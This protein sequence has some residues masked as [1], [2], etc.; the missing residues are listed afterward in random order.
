[1][2]PALV[3]SQVAV[4]VVILLLAF[5]LLGA[6]RGQEVLRWRLDQL[7]ALAP[8]RAGRTG[9]RP[10]TSAPNFT[11]PDLAGRDVSLCDF[12]G[13]DVLLVFTQSGCGPCQAVMPELNRLHARGEVQVVVVNNGDADAARISAA[14]VR[15]RFPVLVQD[16]FALSKKYEVFA[17][18]FAFLID[19]A[20]VVRSKGIAG[21]RQYIGYVVD[22]A[23]RRADGGGRAEPEPVGAAAEA[24]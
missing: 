4:W 1:M 13:R 23:R 15:A 7:Q 2:G 21:T 6:L 19:G 8:V 16:K 12:A 3:V 18:P 9:L 20:G 14:E 5:L 11:L 22:G 17:T 24:S 10:G